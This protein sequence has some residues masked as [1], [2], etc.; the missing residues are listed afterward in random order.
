LLLLLTAAP[1]LI[2][3]VLGSFY[4]GN[5]TWIF[6]TDLGE[7]QQGLGLEKPLPLLDGLIGTLRLG[8][9]R[10]IV[11]GGALYGVFLGALGLLW[12]SLRFRPPFYQYGAAISV[13]VIISA[14]IIN[15]PLAWAVV[16]FGRLLV[17]PLA[18]TAGSVWPAGFLNDRFTDRSG[19]LPRAA[20]SA[21]ALTILFLLVASQ[22]LFAWYMAAIYYEVPS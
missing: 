6:T 2:L 5:P 11:K 4:H 15:T 21:A 7:V 16:R 22:F 19:F 3:W 9:L 17:L 18:W 12:A 10:A 14:L 1:L 13:A 8:G 20:S